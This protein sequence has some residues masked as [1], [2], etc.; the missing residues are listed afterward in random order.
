ME[1]VFIVPVK[2]GP[3]SANVALIVESVLFCTFTGAF[4][5][6]LLLLPTVSPVARGTK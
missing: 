6:S 4:K 1:S 5:S 3:L 2:V